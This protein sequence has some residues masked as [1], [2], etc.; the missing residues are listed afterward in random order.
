MVC[1]HIFIRAFLK[2]EIKNKRE[3][4]LETRNKR[5]K[6]MFSEFVVCLHFCLLLK[7]LVVF[8]FGNRQFRKIF[9]FYASWISFL[10]LNFINFLY[11]FF[12]I[13]DLKKNYIRKI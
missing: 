6:N 7:F 8:Y 13:T 9:K 11:I 12:W 3:E 10:M 2:R 4:E 5:V 1:L